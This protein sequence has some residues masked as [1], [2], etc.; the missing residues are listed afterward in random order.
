MLATDFIAKDSIDQIPPIVVLYGSERYLKQQSLHLLLTSIYGDAQSAQELAT[1]IE[2][3]EA[4]WRSVSDELKTISMW[5][6]KRSVVINAADDFVS[7]NRSSL[8]AY[9]D[10]PA[11]SSL[12]VLD[13]KSWPKSTKLAKKVEKTGLSLECGELKGA[14]LSSWVVSHAQQ[15]YEKSISRSAVALLLELAGTSIG[16][17]D[18]EL[19]KLSSYVGDNKK[20]TDEDVRALVGGWRLE[21]TWN[22]INA[23]R[24][25]ELDVALTELNKLMTAG[26]APQ[27]LLGGISFVYR[28]L[29]QAV[30]TS[31]K[32]RN[33]NGALKSAGVFPRDIPAAETYLRRLG[34][35]RAERIPHLL[36]QA[37]LGM[38]GESSLPPRVLIERLLVELSP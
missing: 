8:E 14:Q 28:K 29:V 26:E 11:K 21:T 5:S 32:T 18:R 30:R 1:T 24:D 34:R 10:K 20:I 12:L 17:L 16:L 2:G 7:A 38:K 36:A 27:K 6:G 22:M 37:D 35:Q 13:V 15:K 25:G 9:A 3:R 19:D 23:V 4:E 33:L 31:A